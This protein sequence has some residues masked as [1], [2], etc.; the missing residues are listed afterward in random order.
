[1]QYILKTLV[2]IIEHIN[3]Y[4]KELIFNTKRMY[5]KIW[6]IFLPILRTEFDSLLLL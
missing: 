6:I 1:M 4:V 5:K 3:T 2:I